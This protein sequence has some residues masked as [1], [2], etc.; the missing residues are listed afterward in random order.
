MRVDK[1]RAFLVDCKMM[2]TQI[3]RAESETIP[4]ISV[5]FSFNGH[6][7]IHEYSGDYATEILQACQLS[8]FTHNELRRIDYLAKCRNDDKTTESIIDKIERLL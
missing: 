8:I 1:N 6:E 3:H 2:V 5:K 7:M 4:R